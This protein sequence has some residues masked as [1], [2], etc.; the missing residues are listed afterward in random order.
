MKPSTKSNQHD[1]LLRL[2][3]K[4]STDCF[5]FCFIGNIGKATKS[6]ERTSPFRLPLR[7]L[8]EMPKDYSCDCSKYY[9]FR[10]DTSYTEAALSVL[11][12]FQNEFFNAWTEIL[13]IVFFSYAIY[14]AQSSDWAYAAAPPAIRAAFV[15]TGLGTVSQHV[16]SLFAHTFQSCNARLSHAIWVVDYAAILL[17]FV[18][19]AP[20]ITVVA[21]GPRT[22]DCESCTWVWVWIF[23]NIF[24]TVPIFGGALWYTAT[25]RMNLFDF[26]LK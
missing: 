1:F 18:H 12:P 3:P 8:V 24:V 6:V 14:S 19:N 17:N 10:C 2:S 15:A 16:C 25:V 11:N 9:G 5:S 22:T 26:C 7:C 4:Y 13:P 20:M 23:A 21:L